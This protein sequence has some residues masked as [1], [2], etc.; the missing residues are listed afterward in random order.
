[1]VLTGIGRDGEEGSRALH[2]E[3]AVVLA[4]DA[5]SSVVWGMPGAV[6]RAGYATEV[7]PLDELSAYVRGCLTSP[8]SKPSANGSEP[9]LA[10]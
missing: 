2:Q 6:A 3:G 8:M 7:L 10:G 4:Q 9:H 1:M 5:S